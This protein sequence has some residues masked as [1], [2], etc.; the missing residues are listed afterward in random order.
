MANLPEWQAR[1]F[2]IDLT[3]MRIGTNHDKEEHERAAK[4][5]EVWRGNNERRK[6]MGLPL[7]PA[8]LA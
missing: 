4:N 3:A 5:R 2:D 1:A 7:E 8:P 6:A